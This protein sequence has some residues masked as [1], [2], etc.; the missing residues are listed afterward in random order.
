MDKYDSLYKELVPLIALLLLN[1]ELVQTPLAGNAPATASRPST[2]ILSLAA[3][4]QS[5]SRRISG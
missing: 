2:R 5:I 1:A 3:D 4:L